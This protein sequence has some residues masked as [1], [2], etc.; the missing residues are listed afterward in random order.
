MKFG[1]TSVTSRAQWTTIA[2]LAQRHRSAG[3]RVLVVCSAMAGVTDALLEI[4]AME[5]NEAAESIIQLALR[6]RQLADDLGID[7]ADIIDTWCRKLQLALDQFDGPRRLAQ[8]AWLGEWIL[9]QMGCLYLSESLE[10]GWVDAREALQALPESQDTQQRALLGA[11]CEAAP[12]PQLEQRWAALQPVLVTQGFVARS[13]AGETVLLGRGGSDTSAALLASRLGAA[14]CE[15]WTDVPGLFSADPRVVQDARQLRLLDYSEALEMAAGGA[16]VIHPRCIRAAAD[17][18]IPIEIRDLSRPSLPGTLIDGPDMGHSGTDGIKAVVC[19]KDM[20]VLLLENRDIRQQVGFLA[21]VFACISDAGV[22]VDLVATSETTT[23]LAIN[24]AVNHLDRPGLESLAGQLRQR[25]RVSVYRDCVC[26]N[27]V[28]RGARHALQHFG[29]GA[30][31]FR[32]WPLLMLS[33]SANDLCISLLVDAGCAGP[34]LAEMHEA[35]IIK[36]GHPPSDAVFGLTWAE[37]QGIDG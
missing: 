37:L 5:D 3:H 23:T 25:C 33:Q 27:L 7:A 8:V 17:A 4:A 30:E 14:I 31:V 15:I 32:D 2:G 24:L 9:T 36:P 21:W 19:Q 22:S 29:A 28:G 6:H 26:I 13:A 34:L 11:H 35:L 12:D 1:G 20:A 18:R 16:R 10:A